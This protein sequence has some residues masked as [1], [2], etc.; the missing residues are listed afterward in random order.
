MLATVHVLASY[1]CL[2]GHVLCPRAYNHI[3][4]IS[5]VFDEWQQER[6]ITA[7]LGP[8]IEAFKWSSGVLGSSS[9]W[10]Q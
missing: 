5:L 10:I 2:S 8:C 3:P 9:M 6:V 7:S 1:G 4:S